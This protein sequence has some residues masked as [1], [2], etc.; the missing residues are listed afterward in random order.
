MNIFGYEIRRAQKAPEKP[1]RPQI[2]N[3][4]PQGWMTPWFQDYCMRKVSG[5]FYEVLREGIP[6]IDSAIRRLIS[7][8]G[9]IRIIGDNAALVRE[10]EDFCLNV[11]V[12]DTQQGIH[13][14]LENASNETFEQGFALAEFVATTDMKDI[15]G[16]RV[17]DSKDIVYRRN[18]EGV[19]GPW[20][21]QP[22]S[23]PLNPYALPGTLIDRIINAQYG[24]IISVT[25]GQEVK[26]NP[27]NKLYFSI[28]N[29]NSDPYGVSIMRSMEFCSQILVTI[30][31][32]FKHVFERFGDP[33]FHVHYKASK[34]GNSE[35]LEGRRQALQT[36]WNTTINAKRAG[37]SSDLVTAGSLE[38]DVV[39]KV[40]G[41][42][43]QVLDSTV[44]LRHVLEQI[45][46]KTNLPAWMLG[47]YWSTTE[48]MATLEVESAL[49]DA[50]IRQLAMLPQFIR[51]FSTVLTMRGRKWKTITTDPAKAG[52][53]GIIFE[54]PN[55][56]DLVAQ[57]QARFL[58]A[59]ADMMGSA[60]NSTQT[61]VSVGGATV[62]TQITKTADSPIEKGDKGGCGCGCE[63]HG[64]GVRP[65]APTG[66]IKELQRPT[67]WPEL[68]KVEAEYEATLKDSWTDLTDQVRTILKLEDQK[69]PN[70]PGEVRTKEEQITQETFTF[71]QKQRDAI[72]RA[73]ENNI[74]AYDTTA[75]DS[76]INWYYGQ[77][78]SLGLI[79][80]GNML[81]KE[82]PILDIIKN[83]EIYD[84]LRR[85]GFDLLKDNATKAI[86]KQIIPAIEEQ[87]IAGAN[88]RTVAS[89][90]N[91]LFG[92]KNSDWERLARSEMSMAA[93]RAKLD[94]WQ[95]WK[96]KMVEFTPAPDA[97]AI[98][99]ALKGDYKI[100]EA[101]IP[102]K[103]THPRCRCSTRPAKSEV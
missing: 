26:L 36:D 77:S 73:M 16:L 70:L 79:Q 65:Y 59:Q 22:G 38:S 21:R 33:M 96:V 9:T 45:V 92:D 5:D 34:S 82:R 90:L 98:C 3:A 57:A 84:E 71:S 100:S 94:E 93:E 55:L 99:M 95:E 19:A 102:V 52:D 61:T 30:E 10:L 97:C 7:L 25:G 1:S 91:K 76:P 87:V 103:N 78:Y 66:T 39:I 24:Q 48:R 12:N 17:A 64:K 46:S 47:I 85:T 50:K 89:R 53:W 51:L 28:N 42:D 69:A 15:A 62:T 18:A 86:V 101:P 4:Q 32:S 67:P 14:F 72:M 27:A 31:N 11:P 75:A 58:N 43:N 13:S 63:T 2:N 40:I 23:R 83:S 6:L 74:S 35:N 8:N 81:G 80:A 49:Q 54:T 29:E 41:A 60:A 56:R 88:P 44:P 20:Y 68:D 37:K